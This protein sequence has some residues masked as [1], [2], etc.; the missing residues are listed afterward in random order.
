MDRHTPC[1]NEGCT[2]TAEETTMHRTNPEEDFP[3]YMC[4]PHAKKVRAVK[5]KALAERELHERLV[6]EQARRVDPVLMEL[7]AQMAYTSG[8]LDML[9]QLVRARM[10]R[11]KLKAKDLAEQAGVPPLAITRL[12]KA[13]DGPALAHV[14]ALSSFFGSSL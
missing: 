7:R 5:A 3:E 9:P 2:L 13:G 6:L 1:A 10:V 4:E 14:R 12:L 8:S 11:D